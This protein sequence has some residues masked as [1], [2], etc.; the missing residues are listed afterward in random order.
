MLPILRKPPLNP[1]K[2]KYAHIK[3]VEGISF[4]SWLDNNLTK[5]ELV[6]SYN[7]LQS[8]RIS[9]S[10]DIVI[11]WLSPVPC[12]TLRELYNEIVYHKHSKS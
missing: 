4:I 6:K 3:L 5:S 10:T 11:Q 2:P 9:P 1:S 12:L 8:G 7:S